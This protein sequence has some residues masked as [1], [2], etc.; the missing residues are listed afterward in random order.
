[1]KRLAL[2][3]AT[4]VLS[5]PAFAADV[6]YN[7]PPAPMPMAI[8][9]PGLTWTGL[10]VGVQGGGAFNP[11]DGDNLSIN[12][13][14]G[15]NTAIPGFTAN[16]NSGFGANTLGSAFGRSFQSS[17]DSGFTGGAHIGYDYQLGGIVLGA[18]AD[19]N[20]I[21]VS[22]TASAFSNTP[23]FY[24]AERSLD[25]FG[26]V[27]ARAGAVVLDRGLLYVS[28]GLAYGDVSYE[29]R[30]NSAAA[31]GAIVR[32]DEDN[33]GYSVGA[34]MD[35]L[36]TQNISFGAEYL[37]T[38]LGSG[39][40]KTTLVRGPFAGG[41]GGTTDFVDSDDFDFH[42]VTAKLSYRFN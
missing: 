1:M 24:T 35:V 4:T 41:V 11:S 16:A 29:F 30:S 39:N 14:F 34:G 36:L 33:F 10:Y 19:I 2:V 27:R 38:N 5:A 8:E 42:T 9:A 40:S 25:Y 32:E 28:G 26:T 13:T 21:D 12:P 20:A 18:V 31:A 23:A 17:F 15:N 7:E 22:K 6:V 37:Y 3:L